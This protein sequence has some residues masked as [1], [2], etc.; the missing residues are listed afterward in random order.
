MA[1][2]M[3]AIPWWRGAVIYEIYPRSFLD[4]N[5]DGIGDLPGIT[6]RLDWRSPITTSNASS[7]A[8]AAAPQLANQ[9][10]ALVCSLRGSVCVY[11]G[12]ELGLAEAD[13]PFEAL[14]DPCGHV[15]VVDVS[16]LPRLRQL[17]AHGVNAGTIEGSRLHLPEHA[18]VFATLA[19]AQ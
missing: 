5:G 4:T 11:Q 10:T 12:E 14:Q 15:S 8:G 16:N 1:C 18:A 2:V 19:Y 9:L 7:L 13:V 3:T 6:E 17:S